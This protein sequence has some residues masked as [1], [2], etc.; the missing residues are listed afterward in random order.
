MCPLT[1]YL[2]GLTEKPK[3]K[4][5]RNVYKVL[6]SSNLH[7]N[8]IP[9]EEGDLQPIRTMLENILNARAKN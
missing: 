5:E 1:D 8:G 3:Y 7:W 4:M 9:I 2:L 6:Y